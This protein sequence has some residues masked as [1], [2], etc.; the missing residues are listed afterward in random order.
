MRVA[1]RIL[2]VVLVVL[3]LMQ[4]IP[5]DRNNPPVTR[6]IHWD[7]PRTAG[8]VQRACM[9]CHSN[10]TKWPWYSY[11]APISWYVAHDVHEGRRHVNFSQAGKKIKWD[12]CVDEVEEGDMPLAEYMWIH[13]SARL[14]HTEREELA[15]G[16]ERTEA[17]LAQPLQEPEIKPAP[18][19]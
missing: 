10:E 8:L 9:D 19:K 3:V 16:F 13:A 7:S 14:T 5:V 15:G 2:I 1:L 12:H 6:N 4:L 17:L 18:G 11:V